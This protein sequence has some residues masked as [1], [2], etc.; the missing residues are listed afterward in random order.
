MTE[1][2]HPIQCLRATQGRGLL[3]EII[4]K[5]EVGSFIRTCRIDI[6][7]LGLKET[8]TVVVRE[9]FSREFVLQR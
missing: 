4:K 9:A 5:R 1:Q 3:R 6:V 2:V 8:K 7:D